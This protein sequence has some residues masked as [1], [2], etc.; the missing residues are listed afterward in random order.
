MNTNETNQK[1]TDAKSPAITLQLSETELIE[2]LKQGVRDGDWVGWRLVRIEQGVIGNVDTNETNQ[3]SESRSTDG[4]VSVLDW[5]S[6]LGGD[7]NTYWEAP[8][9]YHD[10]GTPICFRLKQKIIEDSIHWIE[11][12]DDEILQHS[13]LE[14]RSLDEAKKAVEEMELNIR[15]SCK[16]LLNN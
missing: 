4:S 11:A 15:A 13:P 16:G 7:D 12:H 3:E 2:Q 1:S 9:S 10:E 8:S 14:W 6:D 5:T